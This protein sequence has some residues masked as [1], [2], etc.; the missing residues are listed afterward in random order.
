MTAIQLRAELF[1]ELNI[2]MS[3]ENLMEK[4]IKSLRRINKKR[5]QQ[6]DSTVVD[7]SALPELPESF[8]QLRGMTSHTKAEIAA[9]EKLAYILSK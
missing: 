1:R 4:A 9:D 6:T 5:A 2:I 7:V 8:L 3:D